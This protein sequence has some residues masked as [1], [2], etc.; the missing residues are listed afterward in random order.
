MRRNPKLGFWLIAGHTKRGSRPAIDALFA[1][2]GWTFR[3]E[4]WVHKSLNQLADAPYEDDTS[5]M[6]A[7]LL[8]LGIV[9]D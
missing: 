8:K 5:M 3:G 1:S 9:A 2:N 7:K 4:D 6:V